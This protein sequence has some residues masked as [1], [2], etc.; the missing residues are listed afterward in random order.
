M[1]GHFSLKKRL[2]YRGISDI[3]GVYNLKVKILHLILDH[4]IIFSLQQI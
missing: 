1:F 2:Q 4:Q 3:D